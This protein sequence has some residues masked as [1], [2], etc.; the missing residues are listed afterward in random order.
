MMTLLARLIPEPCS[1]TVDPE[2]PINSAFLTGLSPANMILSL[3]E[4][5]ELSVS[6]L[7]WKN[8][9]HGAILPSWARS[10][11]KEMFKMD[12]QTQW[13]KERVG[14]VESSTGI[15]DIYT[16]PRVK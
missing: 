3:V 6:T 10:A 13:G 12:S 4:C 8:A 11:G 15:Y 9:T 2:R 14:R 7:S 1:G 16:L 5:S